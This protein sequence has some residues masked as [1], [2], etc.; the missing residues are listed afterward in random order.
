MNRQRSIGNRIPPPNLDKV[1]EKE[2]TSLGNCLEQ[3]SLENGLRVH[4]LTDESRKLEPVT[5]KRPDTMKSSDRASTFDSF[6]MAIDNNHVLS[7]GETGDIE[8]PPDYGSDGKDD[9]NMTP[10]S[11]P[12]PPEGTCQASASQPF[13]ISF[14]KLDRFSSLGSVDLS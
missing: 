1:S 4:D 3:S 2:V 8:V 14:L 12:D 11:F 10:L 13:P 7:L 5:L 9:D 6:D